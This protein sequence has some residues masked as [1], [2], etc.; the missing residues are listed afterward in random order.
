MQHFDDQVVI[1]A[2]KSCF[3]TFVLRGRKKKFR[4]SGQG[5]TNQVPVRDSDSRTPL[6]FRWSFFLSV[7]THA[8]GDVAHFD[9][10]SVTVTTI[11]DAAS[12]FLPPFFYHYYHFIITMMKSLR[13]VKTTNGPRI[14]EAPTTVSL[15]QFVW[16]LG[17]SFFIFILV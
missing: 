5:L 17:F 3:K 4:A 14:K 9:T 7:S 6:N 16:A 11:D 1:K 8:L 2:S 12:S 15:F 13:T 10:K